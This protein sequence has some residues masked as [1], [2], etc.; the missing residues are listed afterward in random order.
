MLYPVAPKPTR[1]G[2]SA[3]SQ[4]ASKSPPKLGR[5]PLRVPQACTTASNGDKNN[6]LHPNRGSPIPQS[7]AH[8][9]PLPPSKMPNLLL[10]LL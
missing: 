1:P 10:R 9:I 6:A 7:H 3:S 4:P 8:R 5:L 2:A